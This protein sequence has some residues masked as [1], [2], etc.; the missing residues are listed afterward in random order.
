[1]RPR[2]WLGGLV[3]GLAWLFLAAAPAWAVIDRLLPLRDVLTDSTFVL[4]VKV[5]SLDA[6][7][8]TM[9]LTVDEALKGKPAFTRLPVLLEGDADA[10]KKNERPELLKR[11]APKLPLVLFVMQSEREFTVFAYSNGTW[12]QMT[13]TQPQGAA[14][15][16]WSFG[17]LEPYLRRTFKGTTAEMRQAVADALSGK[18]KPPEVD[19]NEKP[20]LGPEVAPEKK[21]GR[22][23]D[24]PQRPVVR[25][26]TGPAL[27]VVP[28]VLIGGPLAVLASLFPSV[29]GGWRR[30]LVLLSALATTSTVYFVHWWLG[31]KL[32][33][34]WFGSPATLWA[35]LTLVLVAMTYWAWQRH[36]GRVESG[37]A[38]PAPGK[39]ELVILVILGMVAAGLLGY[40]WRER[41]KVLEPGWM[42]VI[43]LA[44][45]AWAALAFCLWKRR[46]A[47]RGP[48]PAGPDGAGKPPRPAVA[49]EVV[50]LTAMSLCSVA[51]SSCV[52]T[53]R[54]QGETETAA[55]PVRVTWA[56]RPDLRGG[57]DASP[58]LDGDR[59]YC[60]VAKDDAFR[61]HGVVYC[62]DRASGAK[63]WEFSDG[64]K[65]KQA[66]SSPALAGGRLYIGEGLHQDSN[67]KVYCL[68]A[69]T[70]E[71]VWEHQTQSHTEATPRVL[72]G[73]V[74]CGAGDDGLFCLDAAT[75][76]EVWHFTGF[77]IDSTPA[78]EGGRVFV[79]SGVGDVYKETMIFCLN[80]AD[81]KV[82]WKVPTGLPVWGPP[83]AGGGVVYFG[84]GNG[85]FVDSD[86]K[87]PAGALLCLKADDGDEVWRFAVKD[88]VLCRPMV[89]AG[90]VYFGCRDGTVYALDRRTGRLKWKRFLASPVVTTPTLDV[91][92]GKDMAARVYVA[93]DGGLLCCLDAANGK[94]V[95]EHDLAAK[96][97]SAVQ[98]FSTPFLAVSGEGKERKLYVGATL[99]ASSRAPVLYC[100]EET[101]E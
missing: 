97:E 101:G 55:D 94:P 62:L 58:L 85:T 84:V 83:T 96:E 57:A 41:V 89:D 53:V 68:D 2:A 35:A 90:R 38:P 79:G 73:K 24:A 9:V 47:A 52:S 51:L 66:F 44:A 61:P 34:T 8:G 45:G 69:A 87:A 26:S 13:G 82:V 75:G 39:V 49:T 18:K 42:Q 63:V 76:K 37:E 14:A 80:A 20:G 50:M 81:G 25:L 10:R 98:M 78:V 40:A 7:K 65:M 32:A 11:L 36:L 71:K 59:V 93:V 72:D 17:H 100:L 31:P 46:G 95:W 16:R 33:G 12:F 30:W 70:G 86:P 15:P 23:D 4:A 6:D 1:M 22:L 60:A 43:V 27:G 64:K 3:L 77:H 91:P 88:G 28:S 99:T 5:D 54:R 92:P 19:R 21:M 67:C 29:F 56:F 74:Y 48:A